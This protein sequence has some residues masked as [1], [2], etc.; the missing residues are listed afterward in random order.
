MICCITATEMKNSN[1]EVNGESENE[2]QNAI[3]KQLLNE[4]NKRHGYCKY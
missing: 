4:K 1:A 2:T 3:F